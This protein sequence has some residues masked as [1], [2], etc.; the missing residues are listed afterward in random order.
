MA[1]LY[2]AQQNKKLDVFSY[3]QTREIAKLMNEAINSNG[4]FLY[5]QKKNIILEM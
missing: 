1:D 3:D 2:R 4:I 5:Q